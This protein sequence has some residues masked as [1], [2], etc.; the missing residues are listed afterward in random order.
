MDVGE[1]AQKL[2][3]VEFDLQHG[4]GLFQLGVMTTGSVNR[5]RDVF[6]YEVEVHFILLHGEI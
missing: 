1:R 5:F 3:H 4:H 6:K 2:I